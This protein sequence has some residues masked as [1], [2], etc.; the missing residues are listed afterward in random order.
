MFW[1]KNTHQWQ[2]TQQQKV[3]VMCTSEDQWPRN[4]FNILILYLILTLI[5]FP[6]AP[7]STFGL[8]KASPLK[9]YFISNKAQKEGLPSV[10]YFA[11]K[12]NLSA[13]YFGD[14]V[15]KETGT[16][17]ME[18]IQ[19]KLIEVAKEKVFDPNKT[20]S[21]IAFELGFKYP[22]HF[23]RTFKQH[24]GCTSPSPSV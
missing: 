17:A 7:C 20:I 16:S 3:R 18:Y 13:N 22:Q 5:H 4:K 8:E 24:V 9:N 14:L 19:N 6:A 10:G 12:L 23:T 15:K 2:Q 11:D 1:F 21:E